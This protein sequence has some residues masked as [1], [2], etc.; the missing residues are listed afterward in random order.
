MASL[1]SQFEERPVLFPRDVFINDRY[2][3]ELSR[4]KINNVITLGIGDYEAK[5]LNGNKPGSKGAHSNVIRLVSL[6]SG[7]PAGMFIMK[8]CAYDIDDADND[9]ILN[10]FSR[11]IK[12]LELARDNKCK[13]VIELIEK[14]LCR[15]GKYDY[16][17]YVMEYA[18]SDLSNHLLSGNLK[19]QQKV[20]ICYDLLRGL[21]ELHN[22][23]VYH[24]DIKHDNLLMCN[25][26]CK[27]ADLGLVKFRQETHPELKKRLGAYGWEAPEAI[28]KYYAERNISWKA[29]YTAGVDCIVDDKSDVFQLGK[30]FWYIFTNKIPVGQLELVN[31]PIEDSEDIFDAIRKMLLQDKS[32]RPNVEEAISLFLPIAKRLG[33]A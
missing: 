31:M 23:G 3:L 15:I 17:Y 13:R 30:V 32:S 27:V 5:Y 9:N 2:D 19:P 21:R 26:E 33:V 4:K 18:D 22:I 29:S 28:N 16:M 14:G 12:A 25:N 10:L 1:R 6:G 8:I 7:Q 11:E 20:L 24:R